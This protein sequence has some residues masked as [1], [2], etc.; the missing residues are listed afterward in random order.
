MS[1]E[2]VK[3][4]VGQKAAELIEQGMVVGLG[5][6][7]TASHFIQALGAKCK[8]GLHIKAVAS[9]SAS[10]KLARQVGI[11][12]TDIDQLTS[13]DITVDS[14]D[15][16]DPK[17][18]M[19]KGGGGALVRE[20]IV[21]SMSREMVVIVDETKLVS[22]LGKH[23]LPVEI[24]TFGHLATLHHLKKLG[25]TGSLRKNG[26]GSLYITDNHNYLYDID[27]DPSK[28]DPPVDHQ[29]ITGVPGV[30]DTGFFIDL[31][32]RVIVGFLDGQIV[33]Q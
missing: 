8:R 20:K 2:Q 24:V 19:I 25:Y 5:T 26:A 3:Q 22:H 30:V 10:E 21:A 31:A 18:Q 23:R 13:I 16:I 33:I 6:G 29:R 12:L 28:V 15:E 32:G 4:A 1:I 14:A 9:S 27:F 7:T 11:P 17:K